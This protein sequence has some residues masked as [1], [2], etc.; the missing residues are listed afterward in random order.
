M[1][2]TNAF[3]ISRMV[4]N[5]TGFDV[6]DY[7][8]LYVVIYFSWFKLLCMLLITLFIFRVQNNEL[9]IASGSGEIENPKVIKRQTENWSLYPDRSI[10]DILMS[11]EVSFILSTTHL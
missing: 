10:L 7:P 2:I 6:Q 4:I 3:D 5:P 8:V 11:T 9:A 1:Q